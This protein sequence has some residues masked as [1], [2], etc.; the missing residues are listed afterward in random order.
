MPSIPY[1]VLC[2]VGLFDEEE[3]GRIIGFNPE[4]YGVID[5]DGVP[6]ESARIFNFTITFKNDCLAGY[7]R[8]K[9]AK[10]SLIIFIEGS[11]G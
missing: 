6:S 11:G 9:K 10:M 5:L 2:P 4:L 8:A 7:I 1:P 3:P